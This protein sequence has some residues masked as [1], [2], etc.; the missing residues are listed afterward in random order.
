VTRKLSLRA[1]GLAWRTVEDELIAIDV[2]ESTYLTANG[3]GLV[4]WEALAAGATSDELA[5]KLV[6]EFGIDPDAARTDADRFVEELRERGL[7][8]EARDAQ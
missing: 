4:L 2:H 5:A 8:D 7:L 1:D 6:A 3:S